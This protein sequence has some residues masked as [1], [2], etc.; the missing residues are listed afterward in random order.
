MIHL[1]LV[2]CLAAEQCQNDLLTALRPK[3]VAA[4]R[5]HLDAHGHRQFDVKAAA[6]DV[7]QEVMV[8]AWQKGELDEWKMRKLLESRCMDFVR[9]EPFLVCMD[10]DTIAQATDPVYS[11]ARMDHP[12]WPGLLHV[13]TCLSQVLRSATVTHYLVPAEQQ[14]AGA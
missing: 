3:L 8:E 6:E 12:R 7:V 5:A 1:N 10:M 9:G 2:E 14:L 11:S 4:A 13:V